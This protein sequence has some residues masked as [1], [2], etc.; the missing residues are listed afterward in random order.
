MVICITHNFPVVKPCYSMILEDPN[1]SRSS[2]LPLEID[3]P[4]STYTY[5]LIFKMRT[6]CLGMKGSSQHSHTPI[7]SA[8]PHDKIG[9]EVFG[10]GLSNVF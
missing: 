5:T 10:Y 3:H 1:V 8:L 9:Q 4:P 6:I 2:P 7:K